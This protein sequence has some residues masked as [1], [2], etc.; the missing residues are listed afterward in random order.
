MLPKAAR[1]VSGKMARL[2][3]IQKVRTISIQLQ[4]NPVNGF[5]HNDVSISPN[6]PV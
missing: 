3:Y 6:L 5:I 2:I 4:K 1:I